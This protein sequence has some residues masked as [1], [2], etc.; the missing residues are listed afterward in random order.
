M[1]TIISAIVAMS[2]V[3]ATVAPAAA[4]ERFSIKQLDSEGRGGHST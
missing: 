1:K 4:Y 3:A 2:F